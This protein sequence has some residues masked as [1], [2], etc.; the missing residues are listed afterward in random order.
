M[1]AVKADKYNADRCT[2]WY[3]ENKDQDNNKRWKT[4]RKVKGQ[5]KATLYLSRRNE[6]TPSKK[7]KK[8]RTEEW[9]RGRQRRMSHFRVWAV[10]H[11]FL[12]T[13]QRNRPHTCTVQSSNCTQGHGPQVPRLLK[14][15]PPD[16]RHSRPA[17]F[18]LGAKCK[19]LR[20]RFP[21]A[22]QEGTH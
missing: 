17:L 12:N 11:F 9:C 7:K 5:M 19:L 20:G 8:R 16:A 22:P 3:N 6:N 4:R 18:I 21:V 13:C 10:S 1:E 15:S 14:H 2:D